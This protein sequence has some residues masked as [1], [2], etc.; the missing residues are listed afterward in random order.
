MGGWEDGRT[1]GPP[2]TTEVNTHAPRLPAVARKPSI[3]G[4]PPNALTPQMSK[5]KK[6][7]SHIKKD[8]KAC[9]LCCPSP[10][11][12]IINMGSLSAP[13]KP[14]IHSERRGEKP[15]HQVKII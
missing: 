5:S 3:A 1:G 14:V 9:S 11:C 7:K 8:G 6:N 4:Q 12:F 2:L 10:K 15:H 13:A